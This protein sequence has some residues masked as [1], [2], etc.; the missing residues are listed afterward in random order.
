VLQWHFLK[1]LSNLQHLVLLQADALPRT[2]K[3]NYFF[4][5]Q[6]E[7][8]N[9]QAMWYMYSPASSTNKFSRFII[10]FNCK[11]YEQIKY[12]FS[13]PYDSKDL[14]YKFGFGLNYK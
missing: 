3:Q 9:K 6:P 5:A 14:L 4:G 13:L 10:T 11:R 7:N 2:L 12:R 1:I 8:Q